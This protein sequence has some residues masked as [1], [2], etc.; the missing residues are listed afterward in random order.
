MEY[1]RIYFEKPTEDGFG[2][3]ESSLPLLN[4][5]ESEGFTEQEKKELLDYA[6]R[7][8]FIQTAVKPR[9]LGLGI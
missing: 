4:V 3:L 6:R 2:F 8:A 5:V 1:I 9:P 7:N